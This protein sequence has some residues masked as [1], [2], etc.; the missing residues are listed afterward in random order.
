VADRSIP[1]LLFQQTIE[2]AGAVVAHDVFPVIMDDAGITDVFEA[3]GANHFT[4]CDLASSSSRA[5][6]NRTRCRGS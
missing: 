4:S 5:L 2:E 6:W 1:F 3:A